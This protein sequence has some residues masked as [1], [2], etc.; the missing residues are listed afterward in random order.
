MYEQD[1]KILE[2]NGYWKLI[3]KY[4]FY[5]YDML[6][7]KVGKF[8]PKKVLYLV[9]QRID[10]EQ[11]IKDKEAIRLAEI[12]EAERL[13]VVQ[14]QMRLQMLADRKKAKASSWKMC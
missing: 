6:N 11:W 12:A 14:E 9:Y 13:K 2:E 1:I 4:Q 7:G 5:R 8:S 3:T 10:H